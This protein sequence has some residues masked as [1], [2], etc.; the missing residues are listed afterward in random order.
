MHFLLG[1]SK[2]NAQLEILA[3]FFFFIQHQIVVLDTHARRFDSNNKRL[4]LLMSTWHG[5]M[6]DEGKFMRWKISTNT[7]Y[8]TL[9][10]DTKYTHSVHSRPH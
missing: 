3:S 4:L 5:V 2:G 8:N 1:L 10:T 9:K 6:V 7:V